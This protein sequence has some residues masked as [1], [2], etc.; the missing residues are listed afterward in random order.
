MAQLVR[1]VVEFQGDMMGFF[2]ACSVLY[3]METSRAIRHAAWR[4]HMQMK[5]EFLA[6][7]PGGRHVPTMSFIQKHRVID[8]FKKFGRGPG[9][10]VR[11]LKARG[12]AYGMSGGY[13]WP[14]GGKLA[15]SIKYRMGPG[16]P[17][18]PPLTASIGW[19]D[20][21]AARTG[22]LFSKGQR[23]VVTP[24]MRGLFSRA[25]IV[26]GPGKHVIVQPPRPVMLYF[27]QG[28]RQWMAQILMERLRRN[29]NTSAARTAAQFSR[30][31]I[32]RVAI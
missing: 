13:D 22:A 4:T 23:T 30:K 32:R 21:A 18:E 15:Q 6:E 17:F 7:V 28:R 3:P 20:K 14:M 29:I 1:T 25:G 31:I 10:S 26:L 19:L 27:Y 16:K 2:Q 11:F 5:T 8:A 12:L 9:G 24:K